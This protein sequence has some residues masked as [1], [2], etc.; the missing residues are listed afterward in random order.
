MA[1][2]YHLFDERITII[3]TEGNV[4]HLG[5]GTMNESKVGKI[6]EVKK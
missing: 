3:D 4:S 2:G 6:N 1:I 5:V